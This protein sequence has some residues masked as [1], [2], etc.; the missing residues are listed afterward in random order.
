[1]VLLSC[2]NDTS[3][4]GVITGSS[5]LLERRLIFRLEFDSAMGFLL[6]NRVWKEMK[7]C[8]RC[9]CKVRLVR[10]GLVWVVKIDLDLARL[11]PRKAKHTLLISFLGHV[12]GGKRQTYLLHIFRSCSGQFYKIL[13]PYRDFFAGNCRMI[14]A[15]HNWD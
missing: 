14:N 10:L 11:I 15:H 9:K 13:L 7:A 6:W 3:P 1:M 5:M 8:R 4:D 2:F 12:L